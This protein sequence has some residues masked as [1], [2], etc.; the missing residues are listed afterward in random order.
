[1]PEL[2]FTVDTQI[3]MIGNGMSDIAQTPAHLQLI[4]HFDDAVFL[5]LDKGGQIR[6]EYERKMGTES[7]GRKW[8]AN[9]AV[10]DRIRMHDLASLPKK[11]KVELDKAHFHQTD[12]KFVRLAMA[13]ESKCLVAEESDYSNAVVKVLQKHAGLFIHSAESACAML[14]AD[15]QSDNKGSAEDNG[16]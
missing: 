2:H 14:A 10:H 15:Q 1:V 11:A 8:L 6:S 4:G 3:V 9:L 7:V 12:R 5:A 13:T 16:G